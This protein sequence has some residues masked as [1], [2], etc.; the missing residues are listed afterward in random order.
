MT[1]AATELLNA[2]LALPE[3][4]LAEFAE[5]LAA[6]VEP[7]AGLHPA[8]GPE[9]RRRAAQLDSGEVVGVPYE[10]VRRGMRAILNEA[11]GSRG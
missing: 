3:S 10:E 4:E 1:Q 2:V 8:W 11:G 6:S 7:P 5:L 9:L